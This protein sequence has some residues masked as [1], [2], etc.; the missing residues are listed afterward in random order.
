MFLTKPGD[1]SNVLEIPWLRLDDVAVRF[2]LYMVT[3]G[4]QYC[5]NH[6]QGTLLTV[7]GVTEE[8]LE[9][10]NEEKGLR[11]QDI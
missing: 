10:D 6:S 3:F 11:T 1:Y 8:P 4:S 5:I 7:Q 2:A 9:P